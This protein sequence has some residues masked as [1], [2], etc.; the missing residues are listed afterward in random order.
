MVTRDAWGW[1]ERSLSALAGCTPPVF[2]V[3]VVDNMSSPATVARLEHD[4]AGIRLLRNA[5]NEGF[6]P[7]SNQGAA[8]AR[9]E[10]LALL[11]S[12][13]EVHEGWLEP[14]LEVLDA[15]P[16]CAAV[17]PQVV[18]LDGSLQEAGALVARDGSTA[19]CVFQPGFR[20]R[21]DYAGAECLLVR[22]AAFQAVGGFADVY[23]PAYYEDV[24]LCFALAEAGLTVVYE[25]RSVS[26]T[27]CTAR[28]AAKRRSCFP[29][30]I[31][32]S[33]PPVGPS[34]L[35]TG[36]PG[37]TP[38]G[39]SAS[40]SANASIPAWTVSVTSSSALYS[41]SRPASREPPITKRRSGVCCQ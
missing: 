7:A 3:I 25:P 32:R 24:E 2:E 4:V 8:E 21:I 36:R 6:G 1:I 41:S 22:R 11:N 33:S 26:H 14:L 37:S 40:R 18:N 20:R 17:A 12:D 38:A 13:L 39:P 35:R 16:A 31:A 15:D 23:A 19:K 27:R 10:L 30:A 5:H 29:S 34:G 9:G 28:A